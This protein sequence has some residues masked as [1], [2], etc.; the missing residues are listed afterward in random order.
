[1]RY[2]FVRMEI[3]FGLEAWLC[4]EV[5]YSGSSF[6]NQ[7]F[8]MR[9][10]QLSDRSISS[11]RIV[12]RTLHIFEFLIDFFCG[13]FYNS[14]NKI[15]IIRI[16][17]FQKGECMGSIF[18]PDS[19]FFG[20]MS[21]VANL[22]ILNL[23]WMICCLPVVTIVPSTAAMYYVAMKMVKK[24]DSL[25]AASFFHSF[26]QNLK[27]GIILTLIFLGAGLLLYFDIM[28]CQ[29]ISTP[30]SQIVL[31]VLYLVAACVIMTAVYTA[32]I[33]AKFYHTLPQ[34]LKNAFI[35]AL[36][37][38]VQTVVILVL[39]LLPVLLFLFIPP[40]FSL[41]IPFWLLL[42]CA[43]I[44]LLCSLMFQKIFSKFEVTSEAESNNQERDC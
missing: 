11:C 24:E 37:H 16:I 10:E 15:L 23:L 40:Y 39:N 20:F 1:M 14:R 34:A 2:H 21:N 13:S 9:S 43:A 4:P 30:L 22:M 7:S 31:K 29:K 28:V 6:S 25:I 8:Q 27:Q 42:G 19:K 5:R 36:V 32:P 44:A 17:L 18:H 38:P 3:Y 33:L 26:K 12:C 41:S 35:L